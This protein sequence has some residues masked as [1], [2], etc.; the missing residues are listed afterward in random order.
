MR[1]SLLGI[2]SEAFPAMLLTILVSGQELSKASFLLLNYFIKRESLSKLI[3]SAFHT[4]CPFYK[5][6]LNPVLT[7]GR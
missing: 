5:F 3:H 7:W 1:V 6:A 2:F 4:M